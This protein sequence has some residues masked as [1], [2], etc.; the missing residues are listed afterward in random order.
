MSNNNLLENLATNI[1]NF[2]GVFLFLAGAYIV[3]KRKYVKV[4]NKRLFWFKIV[5]VILG[6]LSP[7][8]VILLT[9]PPK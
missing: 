3:L 6:L 1:R 5:L 7:L 9:D 4:E 2:S 8:I